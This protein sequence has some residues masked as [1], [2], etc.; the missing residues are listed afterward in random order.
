MSDRWILGIDE[1]G[2][3]PVLG[4]MVYAFAACPEAR[5]EQL[6]ALGLADSKTLTAEQR[7]SLL[8]A[9]GANADWIQHRAAVIDA[10]SLSASMIRAHKVSLNE[11][12]FDCTV[13]LIQTAVAEHGLHIVHA[14][15]DTVGDA[16]RYRARLAAVFPAIEFTVTPRAD[17]L[18]PIVSAASIVAKTTRDRSL[19]T[20]VHRERGIEF[21]A[22]LGSGYPG[23]EVTKQWLR[24]SLEPVFGFPSLVRFSW[25]TAKNLMKDS[26]VPVTWHDE[27]DEEFDDSSSANQP[28]LDAFLTGRSKIAARPP[29]FRRLHLTP[30]TSFQ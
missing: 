25:A 10:A 28:R 11:V 9:I 27:V 7:Q 5:Q 2:R 3:G 6:K 19:E 14:Y 24:A 23:D 22:V 1:A 15:I 29:V 16:S 12:A 20:Y 13:G 17:A 30:V 18:F 21:S 4:P 8:H 26:C